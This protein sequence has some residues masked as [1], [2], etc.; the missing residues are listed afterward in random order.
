MAIR[1]MDHRA[2][3]PKIAAPTLI[4]AGSSDVAT[5]LEGALFMQ[6]QIA[7]AALTVLEAAHISNI[8][9]AGSFSG[10]VLGFL[11]QRK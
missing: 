10:E 6:K 8:E 1:D 3:L 9:Q 4:I 5:P 7:G 2:L 11:T